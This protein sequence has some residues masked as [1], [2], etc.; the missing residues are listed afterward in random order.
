MRMPR[1]VVRTRSHKS[2]CQ[3]IRHGY[4]NKQHHHIIQASFN[5]VSYHCDSFLRLA[6]FYL[7]S[8][9]INLV[10][11]SIADL[12]LDLEKGVFESTLVNPGHI[13][14]I[15]LA[16]LCTKRQTEN[17]FAQHF[18]QYPREKFRIYKLH[19]TYLNMQKNAKYQ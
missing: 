19:Y 6:I 12:T 14:S 10:I 7:H 1:H 17:I 13:I 2:T 5:D 9:S 11:Y 16:K 4:G 15:F 8:A 18:S 3:E